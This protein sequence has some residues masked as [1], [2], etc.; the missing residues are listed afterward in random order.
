MFKIMVVEDDQKISKIMSNNLKKWGYE[1]INIDEFDNIVET[2]V[3][4]KPHLILMDINLPYFDGFYYCKKIRE[5]SKVPIIFI[6]SRDGNMDIVMAINMGGDDFLSKPF[7]MEVLLVKI[8]ALLRRT[9]SYQ[10]KDISVL[11][12]NNVILN[13]K[14]YTVSFNDKEIELSKNEFKILYI[15]MKNNNKIISRE[16][17][18]RKLW[19][20]ESFVDDNTLTVNI[21]RLR[22]KLLNLDL[23]DFIKTKR[24]EGYIIK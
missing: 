8:K 5:L 6:S 21:N 22:K 13:L 19:E 16:F 12:Y 18:M 7:S 2:Y 9:Y 17:I 24:K 4:T 11:E 23:D 14:D 15:L 1:I 10:D 3:R 20:D